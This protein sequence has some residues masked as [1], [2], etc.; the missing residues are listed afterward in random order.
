MLRGSKMSVRLQLKSKRAAAVA[1]PARA[2]D[3]IAGVSA[4]WSLATADRAFMESRFGH[5]FSKVRVH[6]DASAAMSAQSVNARAYTLGQD[7]VFGAGQYAPGTAQGRRLL[8]HELTHVVQQQGAGGPPA[9]MA[10]RSSGLTGGLTGDTE[11]RDA[12][13]G[14][15]PEQI[16]RIPI[17]EKIRICNRLLNGWVSDEDLDTV[18]TVFRSTHGDEL[19]SLKDV[20]EGRVSDLWDLGQRAELRSILYWG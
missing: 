3:R 9:G 1:P 15:E 2:A 10:L 18:R 11:I 16:A 4:S 12:I 14:A 7:I 8:A 20:L 6:A 13:A 17:E 19:L 5:D